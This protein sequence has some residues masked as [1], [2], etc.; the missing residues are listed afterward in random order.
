[1]IREAHASLV[2]ASSQK[3]WT[4][5]NSAADKGHEGV[6]K[7]LVEAKAAVDAANEVR[8]VRQ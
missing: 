5:L 3:G 4:P 7:L 6:V 1:L 8:V 2:S